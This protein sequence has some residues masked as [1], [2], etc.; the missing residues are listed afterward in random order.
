VW[1]KLAL[2]LILYFLLAINL[3]IGGFKLAQVPTCP[4][5]ETW[6]Y[7][8]L[9]EMWDKGYFLGSAQLY[10]SFKFISF[11]CWVGSHYMGV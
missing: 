4:I 6:E 1:L 11:C 9:L 3:Q 7:H 5:P 10:V 2:E 8:A